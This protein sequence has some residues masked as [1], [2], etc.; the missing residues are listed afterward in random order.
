MRSYFNVH[1]ALEQV[2]HEV[3]EK[4]EEGPKVMIVGPPD[5]GKSSLAKILLNYAVKQE[6]KPLF[7][8][9]DPTEG[10]VCIPG[11]I[12][13]TAIA[14][15]IEVEDELGAS[16]ALTGT[17]P[18]AYYYGYPTI[19]EKPKL[20]SVLVSRLAQLAKRK[21]EDVEVRASGMIIDTPGEFAE[22]AGYDLLTHAVDNF[23][24]NA[25]LVLGHERLYS[26]LAR[27][28]KDN[29]AISV[30][31]LA[32]SGGVVSRDKVFRRQV[33]MH[34]IREYFYGTPKTELSPYSNIVGFA[35]VNIRRVGGGA[36]APSS[37]LPLGMAR[38]LQENRLVKVDPGD[39][40]LHSIL[41]ISNATV[42]DKPPAAASGGV[43]SGGVA[44]G[45]AV[46]ALTVEPEVDE[47]EIVLQNNVAGFLYVS[48]VDEDKKKLTVL[49]PNPVRLPRRY[50][51]MAA[52]KWMET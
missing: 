34:K 52:Q 24:A 17:S 18:L 2:R 10:S 16:P 26:D 7:V 35:D 12:A 47:S 31:K 29:A 1:L 46:G 11:T 51:I 9:I 32:K 21:L 8:D 33:Q 50:L 43:A 48:E 49:A 30:V 38:K 28:Y 36:L 45:G 23:G 14:R 19:A 39:I 37:A 15:P 4:G 20:Y 44:G 27:R 22:T 5:V 25:I 41:A 6:R 3:T 40:L 13:A 42:P